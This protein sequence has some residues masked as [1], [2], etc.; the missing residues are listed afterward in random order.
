MLSTGDGYLV[1]DENGISLAASSDDAS[2]F[3]ID[4]G[5]KNTV[6]LKRKLL[7]AWAERTE[8]RRCFQ[9][10][11]QPCRSLCVAESS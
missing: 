2:M 4:A 8:R 10:N 1:V 3:A 11:D 6:R 7:P 9:R 5:R